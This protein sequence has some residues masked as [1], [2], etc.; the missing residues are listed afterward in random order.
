MGHIPTGTVERRRSLQHSVPAN[1]HTA[2][3]ADTD[4]GSEDALN[5]DFSRLLWE[6]AW[7]WIESHIEDYAD[8]FRHVNWDDIG[9]KY[10]MWE[11]LVRLRIESEN[12]DRELSCIV[13]VVKGVGGI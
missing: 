10:E 11:K 9:G 2:C 12:L 5:Q 13:E 1:T 7:L 4:R 6:A 8:K 3:A